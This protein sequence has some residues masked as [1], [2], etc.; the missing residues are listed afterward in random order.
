MS[1]TCC[2]GPL[3]TLNLNYRLDFAASLKGPG[4]LKKLKLRPVDAPNAFFFL[5][6]KRKYVLYSILY[7]YILQID[8]TYLKV[9]I[10]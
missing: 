10:C 7:A 6:T 8:C 2:S 4:F 1:V 3:R 5:S 9:C